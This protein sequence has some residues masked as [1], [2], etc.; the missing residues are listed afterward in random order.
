MCGFQYDHPIFMTLL[1]SSSV[2]EEEKVESR[3]ASRDNR[4]EGAIMM[5]IAARIDPTN[6]LRRTSCLHPLTTSEVSEVHSF[7]S[8]AETCFKN[9]GAES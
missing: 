6:S 1:G 8:K 9:A 2:D 5:P 3:R 7:Y 4:P